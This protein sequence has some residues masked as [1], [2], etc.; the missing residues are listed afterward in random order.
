MKQ[1]IFF[2][3]LIFAAVKYVQSQEDYSFEP[4]EI[5]KKPFS[6]GGSAEF[7]PSFLHANQD[8]AFSRLRFFDKD[9]GDFLEI[10]ILNIELNGSYEKGISTFHF[11]TNTDLS[12]S[13]LGSDEETT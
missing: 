5:E 1:F 8:S 2:L 11:W 4:S 9:E 7:H 6:F 12:E 10:Y 13:Y 3:F